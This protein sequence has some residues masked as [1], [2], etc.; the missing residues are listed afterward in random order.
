FAGIIID[1]AIPYLSVGARIAELGPISGVLQTRNQ[2]GLLALIGAIT[3]ATELRTRSVRPAIGVLSLIGAGVCV[4]LTRS[5]IIIA[6]AGI[7]AL[8][9]AVLFG[10]RR[11][12]PERRRAW[13][14]TI[15]GATVALVAGAWLIR[16]ALV[17]LFNAEGALTYR[18][19]L[20]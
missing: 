11:V 18:L 12:R 15:L 10:V 8:G 20:W 1:T 9:A 5:P 14:F 4:V 17:A 3:F 16:G 19:H 7:V 6:A 2:L 13:Q